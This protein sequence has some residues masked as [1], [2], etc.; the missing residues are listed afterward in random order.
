MALPNFQSLGSVVFPRCQ[1]EG[2]SLR[3]LYHTQFQ[4]FWS[5]VSF[6]KLGF[7]M[8]KIEVK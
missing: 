3:G 8:Y 2:E 7:L 4:S 1:E 6:G 5:Q